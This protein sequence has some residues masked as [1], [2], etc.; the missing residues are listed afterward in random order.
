[1]I[2]FPAVCALF[3]YSAG[4]ATTIA[5]LSYYAFKDINKL[6]FKPIQDVYLSRVFCLHCLHLLNAAVLVHSKYMSRYKYNL[7]KNHQIN[8]YCVVSFMTL[9]DVSN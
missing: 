3:Q 2:S 9:Y 5:L 7:N 4:S 8:V 1:M 6:A